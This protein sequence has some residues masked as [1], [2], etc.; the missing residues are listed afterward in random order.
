MARTK[1]TARRTT[2]GP[3]PPPPLIGCWFPFKDPGFPSQVRRSYLPLSRLNIHTI[4]KDVTSRT[5]LTQS[6]INE[7]NKNLEDLV[8]SFP[9]YGGV[10]VVSF[11]ATIGDV[12]VNGI[13]KDKQQAHLE[14]KNAVAKGE[15]AALLEQLPEASDVFTTHIGNVPAG[16]SVVVEL[17]YIDELN[18]DAQADGLR[19]TIPSSI[20]PRYGAT[21][22]NLLSSPLLSSSVQEAIQIIVDVQSPEGCPVQGIQSPSHP[23]A[24]NIGRT[25]DMPTEAFM[26]H[27]GSATLSLNCTSFDKDFVIMV[28]VANANVPKAL[29]E[30]HPT[31]AGQRAL[32]VTLV[33]TFQLPSGPS[34][35]VFILDR[36][37]SMGGKMSMVIQAMNT[38]LKSLR[39]GVKFNICSF[40]SHFSFI[41][42]RSKP[43]NQINLEEALEHVNALDSNFG[44]TEMIGP[45]QA[46]LSQRDQDLAL[47]V[48]ILTDGQ[49]WGQDDL[50][51][52]IRESSEHYGSRFFS[53][54][55]G[56]GA[57]TAL[58]QGI[59]T[60]GNG[61][62]QFVAEGELMDKKMIQ[63]LKGA[64]TPHST[65]YS[66]DMNYK[67]D[68]E[69]FEIVTYE[70][71]S[72][73]AI[74]L[75][76]R[77]KTKDSHETPVAS[78]SEKS[79]GEVDL[80]RR[81]D[82][83]KDRFAHVP[84]VPAPPI[85]QAPVQ[86]P[87]LYPFS[88]TTIYLLLDQSTYGLTP[89]SITLRG[90]SGDGP[91]QLEIEVDDIGRGETF[92]QLAARK[93]VSELERGHGWLRKATQKDSGIL[94]KTHYNGSWWTE[95][96]EREAIR[97]GVMF[98]IPGKWCSFIA[99]EG[100]KERP[101][102]SFGGR[103][104][105][106]SGAAPRKQL[107]SHA[108]RK[109]VPSTGSIAPPRRRRA[110]KAARKS[111][112]SGKRS[113]E[114]SA[115]APSEKKDASYSRRSARLQANTS[116]N[117]KM[118]ALIRLQKFDGSWEWGQSLF[119]ITGADI[120]KATTSNRKNSIVATA[121]A[122]AFFRNR[123]A[124]EADSWELLVEKA[125]SW[126]DSQDGIDSE[127]EIRE[128]GAL[129]S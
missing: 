50:F 129:L 41:W 33:P 52:I 120:S 42:P 20:A 35:I 127:V 82:A 98:Q 68:D 76:V 37:G 32:L 4:I 58:V 10:T 62:S 117:E 5:V 51:K 73:A 56:N 67:R 86:L 44:G 112:P 28:N 85:L 14:F 92:H 39:V 128:A 8:Y 21:P 91:I 7:T 102:V 1:Q 45:V 69:D 54:G 89:E 124:H 95:I 78:A 57:S 74:T 113:P 2:T 66:L 107:A 30:T 99:R 108:C 103:V 11:S 55:I 80:N 72:R 40:G 6:F 60:E 13:V 18:Y 88:R 126:L 16:S 125:G 31:I 87:P 77:E 38:M 29:L 70:D 46:T 43:Y 121:L 97:L 114:S 12:R 26:P 122:I 61:A 83:K 49:I 106:T 24:V 93:A 34:E 81:E 63:L 79:S 90:S 36:S 110:S 64:L 71:V 47:N 25:T 101:P 104:Y 96:V 27:R 48:I 116:S 22:E 59:A 109:S 105:S 94:L 53:L 119:D 111:A 19:L 23:V 123:L 17:V 75:P 65:N 84:T 3:L 15:V 100:D 118:R 9:L 115:S